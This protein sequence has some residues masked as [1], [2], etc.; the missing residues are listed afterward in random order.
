M[1]LCGEVDD[2]YD[3]THTLHLAMAQKKTEAWCQVGNANLKFSSL[4][5]HCIPPA[6]HVEYVLYVPVARYCHLHKK[7]DT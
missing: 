1:Y 6:H 5:F 3:A 7:S 4:R 2:V